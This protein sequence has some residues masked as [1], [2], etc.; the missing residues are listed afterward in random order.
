[1][2]IIFPSS[3]WI[4]SLTI[5]LGVLVAMIKNHT[6]PLRLF[7]ISFTTEKVLCQLLRYRV[8]LSR[9]DLKLPITIDIKEFIK[10]DTANHI[11]T[12]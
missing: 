9:Q 11:I 12:F 5:K 2:K 7:C 6:Q 8:Q 1:M 10:T 3:F 4:C